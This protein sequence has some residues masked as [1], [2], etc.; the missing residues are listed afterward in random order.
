MVL[1]GERFSVAPLPHDS[2]ITLQPI[3]T[4]NKLPGFASFWDTGMDLVSQAL[5]H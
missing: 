2:Q 4:G 3:Q 1:C 5:V